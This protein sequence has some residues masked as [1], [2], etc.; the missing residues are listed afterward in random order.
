MR[1]DLSF[2]NFK[3]LQNLK[4]SRQAGMKISD[5]LN[6]KRYG[7]IFQTTCLNY[8]ISS[9]VGINNYK[10]FKTKKIFL[11]VSFILGYLFKIVTKISQ[12]YLLK[13][14]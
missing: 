14:V 4:K 1:N 5:S 6:K 10:Y 3:E 9:N 2:Q 12:Q 13:V 7:N 8:L 11:F